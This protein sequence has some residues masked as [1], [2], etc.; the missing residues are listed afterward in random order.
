MAIVAGL[1]GLFS[2]LTSWIVG[3]RLVLLA[4]RT[5]QL[6]E[7]LIGLALFLTGGCWS[8]LVAVGRQAAAL[9][10]DVRATLV[11]VGCVCG[12]VGMTCLAVFTWR[13][14][15]PGDAWAAAAAGA[16]ALVLCGV[17][18]GQSAGRGWVDFARTESGPWLLASWIGVGLYCWSNAEA[19]RQYGMQRRRAALGLA[20]PVVADRMR[21]WALAMAAAL[22]GSLV[23]ALCQ[24]LGVPIAGTAVGLAL[25]AVVACVAAG[26]LWLAFVPPDAYLARVRA[27]AAS[28]A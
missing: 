28:Q 20:D 6:P 17:F 10:D 25:T 5:R 7:L 11:G 27:S 26:C 13:T 15:R 24:L 9:P 23:L 22:A 8:P 2:V 3:A 1:A 16:V 19:W 12:V 21:L 18:A 14:Y 4:R